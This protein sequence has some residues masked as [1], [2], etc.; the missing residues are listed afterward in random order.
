MATTRTMNTTFSRRSLRRTSSTSGS[1]AFLAGSRLSRRALREPREG[2]VEAGARFRIEPGLALARTGDVQDRA[3]GRFN[4]A[5][6]GAAN[7]R[8]IAL[9][10][11]EDRVR[12][13]EADRL[14]GG[15]IGSRAGRPGAEDERRVG[16]GD[17]AR[18]AQRDALFERRRR[19]RHETVARWHLPVL[20][21]AVHR[22]ASAD[23][24]AESQRG[25]ERRA[26]DAGLSAG[27]HFREAHRASSLLSVLLLLDKAL[28]A[29]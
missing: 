13:S 12:F 19:D 1:L 17:V 6:N 25:V 24:E 16:V 18:G 9:V 15:E 20:R 28:R 3:G 26:V 2:D 23:A 5:R 21:P 27:D 4:P 7:R 29:A 11:G 10:N 22:G 14:G 8:R